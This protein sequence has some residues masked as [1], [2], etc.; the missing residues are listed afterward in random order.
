MKA[1]FSREL[2]LLHFN[3]NYFEGNIISTLHLR[4]VGGKLFIDGVIY[5]L[6]H[7]EAPN[8]HGF[9][10][11]E[12]GKVGSRCLDAGGHFNPRGTQHGGPKD[13]IRHIGDLGNVQSN[14][15]KIYVN[16]QDTQASLSG[17]Y[18]VL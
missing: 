15:G 2:H 5:G 14:H 3:L 7:D 8:L 1:T 10:I 12:H 11:H 18:S 17:K 13:K 16:V 4:E 6:P 9:H